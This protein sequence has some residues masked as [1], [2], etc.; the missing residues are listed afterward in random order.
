MEI[1]WLKDHLKCNRLGVRIG[2]HRVVEFHIRG[3]Q[4]IHK[5]PA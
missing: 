4:H 3:H 2:A 1:G 5:F